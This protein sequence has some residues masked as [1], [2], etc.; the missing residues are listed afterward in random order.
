[1]VLPW[2]FSVLLAWLWSWYSP[3]DRPSPPPAPLL[4]IVLS[5]ISPLRMRP[6]QPEYTPSVRQPL[7]LMVLLVKYWSVLSAE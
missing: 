3:C 6:F 1:M 5:A 4:K 2:I 7:S